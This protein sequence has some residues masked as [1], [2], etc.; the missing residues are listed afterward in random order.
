M[1]RKPAQMAVEFGDP[2]MRVEPHRL[3]QVEVLAL[4]SHEI[5]LQ[6]ALGPFIACHAIDDKPRSQAK[7]RAL[8][9]LWPFESP[10]QD[11][12]RRVAG[13]AVAMRLD[14]PHRPG[15]SPARLGL[16]Q[17]QRL[18]RGDLGR[19][20]DRPA[21]KDRPQH[22][23]RVDPVAERRGDPADH[24]VKRRKMLDREQ[25]GHRDAARSPTPAPGRCASGRR[26]SDSRR[27]AWD[28]RRA[29]RPRRHRRRDR[30]GAARC[31]SSAWPRSRPSRMVK[32]CSGDSD[33]NVRSPSS[34]TPPHPAADERRSR[35]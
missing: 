13:L 4:P 12:E 18:D 25:V 6:Q 11:I 34:N 20:G 10:D 24:L 9:P 35:A 7:P 22:L 1:S 32:N 21:W 16:E 14:P 5:P 27:A 31:P 30:R 3:D 33:T 8:G 17:A 23:D 19:A 15:I 26:S 2:V 28:R 29:P